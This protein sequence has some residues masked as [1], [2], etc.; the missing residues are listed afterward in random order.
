MWSKWPV[1]YGKIGGVVDMET[2]YRWDVPSNSW[3]YLS[4][5]GSYLALGS[6]SPIVA[7]R[8]GDTLALHSAITGTTFSATKF[9]KWSKDGV[10]LLVGS[11]YAPY[12]IMF[13]RVGD[14][15][16]PTSFVTHSNNI[17]LNADF[18]PD[19]NY[20]AIVE[21][22]SVNGNTL[23]IYKKQ[24]DGSWVWLYLLASGTSSYTITS[25]SWSPDGS[26][27]TFN[28]GTNLYVFKRTGDSFSQVFVGSM[29]TITELKYDPTGNYI[30]AT[31]SSTNSTTLWHKNS[32][33]SF[34]SGGATIPSST[35]GEVPYF[36]PNGYIY[37]VTNS[38]S[39]VY[40]LS[41]A[42]TNLSTVVSINPGVGTVTAMTMTPDGKYIALAAG[43]NVYLYTVSTD[44]KSLTLVGSCVTAS[45]VNSMEFL[46]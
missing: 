22:A 32:E 12:C 37:H 44:G 16:S 3:Q 7:N 28:E 34:S 17:L 13:K 24:T 45:I 21:W 6:H 40:V 35:V 29:S 41:Y 19:G 5:K 1:I 26:Y 31:S 20:L 23:Q 39:L 2:A 36:S 10:N 30:I 27:F 33:T 15:F 42:G 18:S 38:S 14:S 4:Q 8:I 43:T 46:N 25:C 11:N 9:V